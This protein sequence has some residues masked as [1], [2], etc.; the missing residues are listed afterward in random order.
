LS[1]RKRGV[2]V[3][4]E[5]LPGEADSAAAIEAFY[6]WVEHH[7]GQ[8]T[9]PA[10]Q[11]LKG[12]FHGV[13]EARYVIRR[14]FRIVD[15]QAKSVG[16][17]PLE[18]Q[19]LI[20]IFGSPTTLRVIDFAERLDIAAAFASRL[21]KRLAEKGLV[22]RS[23]STDDRRSTFVEVTDRGRELLAEIDSKVEVHVAYFQ[24]QLSDAERA[25]ALGI[26][27]FYLG[28]SPRLEDIEGL[29]DLVRTERGRRSSA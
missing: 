14:V 7:R 1:D 8:R 23:A 10:G 20:Q 29:V 12:Y 25:A 13:A 16:L 22:E 19:A 11:G 17:E 9:A 2:G 4:A 27:A 24:Q 28:A 21:V 26:F 15:E 6:D 18:H 5:E 3:A